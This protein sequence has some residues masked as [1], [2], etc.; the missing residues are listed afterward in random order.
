MSQP[1]CGTKEITFIHKLLLTLSFVAIG[2]IG[3]MLYQV[4]YKVDSLETSL[5]NTEGKFLRLNNEMLSLN[6]ELEKTNLKA[7]ELF[8]NS[9]QNVEEVR[10]IAKGADTKAQNAIDIARFRENTTKDL[11]TKKTLKESLKISMEIT[12]AK[13]NESNKRIIKHVDNSN[14][15]I[16]DEITNYVSKPSK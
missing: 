13:I 7:K 3:A 16:I 5:S 9:N 14:Q 11:I 2:A 6:S 10:V 1:E 15:L 8:D 4:S 12:D